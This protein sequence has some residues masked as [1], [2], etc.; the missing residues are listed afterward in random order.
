[1][2]KGDAPFVSAE[3]IPGEPRYDIQRQAEA[4]VGCRVMYRNEKVSSE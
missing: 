3:M 1:V 2:K 4:A